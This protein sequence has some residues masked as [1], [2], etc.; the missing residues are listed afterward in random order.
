MIIT[1]RGEMACCQN[2]G[3]R[4]FDQRQKRPDIA[5]VNRAALCVS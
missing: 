4:F 1:R 3:K 2:V 5:D